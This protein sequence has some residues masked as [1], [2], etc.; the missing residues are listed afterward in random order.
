MNVLLYTVI[1]DGY[2]VLNEFDAG[3][4]E[5]DFICVTDTYIKSESW[6]IKSVD[7]FDFNPKFSSSDKN[8]MLKFCPHLFFP[9]YDYYIYLDG[10]IG[11]NTVPSLVDSEGVY[12]CRHQFNRTVLDE[13]NSCLKLNKISKSTELTRFVMSGKNISITENNIIF[14]PNNCFVNNSFEKVFK[15]FCDFCPRDQL[16]TPIVMDQ[17]CISYGIFEFS[18][19][20]SSKHFTIKLHKKEMAMPLLKRVILFFLINFRRF[21]LWKM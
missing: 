19:R 21:S 4:S 12:F 10:N 15:I 11:I 9:E 1:L 5:F 3:E 6:E 14:R 8:R 2:D 18:P 7:E 16:I 13:Y 20:Y 17:D